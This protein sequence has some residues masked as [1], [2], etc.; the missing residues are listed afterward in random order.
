MRGYATSAPGKLMLAGEYAVLEGAEALVAAVGITG[1]LLK[2][3]LKEA[4]KIAFYSACEIAGVDPKA[5]VAAVAA[6]AVLDLAA[7]RTHE[8]DSDRSRDIVEGQAL[9]ALGII[10][11]LML[12]VHAAS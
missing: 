3:D 6:A 1:A 7:R 8:L 4:L 5:G 9:D 10:H 11:S 12:H 2:G